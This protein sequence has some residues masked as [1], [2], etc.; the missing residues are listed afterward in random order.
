MHVDLFGARRF[1]F[2]KNLMKSLNLGVCLLVLLDRST[3][4]LPDWK[5]VEFTV[6]SIQRLSKVG[7]G[8]GREEIH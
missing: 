2:R 5:V 6:L 7:E 8:L 1:E 4:L 3:E